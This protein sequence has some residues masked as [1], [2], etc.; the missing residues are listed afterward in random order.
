MCN[1]QIICRHNKIVRSSD[2]SKRLHKNQV[3]LRKL[4]SSSHRILY[5]FV[6]VLYKTQHKT[7]HKT[8]FYVDALNINVIHFV[9]FFSSSLHSFFKTKVLILAPLYDVSYRSLKPVFTTKTF[10]D[11]EITHERSTTTTRKKKHSYYLLRRNLFCLL[12]LK[13]DI[14]SHL[15]KQIARRRR[16]RRRLKNIDN[17]ISFRLFSSNK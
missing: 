11:H 4:N 1:N 7:K 5:P 13:T 2:N 3:L 8:L 14:S 6:W 9:R 15:F 10:L 17:Q 12:H 16:R